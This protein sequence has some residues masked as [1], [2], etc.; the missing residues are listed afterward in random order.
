MSEKKPSKMSEKKS[1][2]SQTYYLEDVVAEVVVEVEV[3][4][5]TVVSKSAKWGRGKWG[6]HELDETLPCLNQMSSL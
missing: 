3:V 5:E 4:G 2:K 1:L 6:S